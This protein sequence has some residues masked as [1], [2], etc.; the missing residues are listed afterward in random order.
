MKEQPP[1]WR[2]ALTVLWIIIVLGANTRMMIEF[3]R[4]LPF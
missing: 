2:E 1:D 3:L 4:L